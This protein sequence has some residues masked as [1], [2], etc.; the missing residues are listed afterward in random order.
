LFRK[1][2]SLHGIKLINPDCYL[3]AQ[4]KNPGKISRVCKITM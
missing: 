4:T 3:I 2:D 1:N